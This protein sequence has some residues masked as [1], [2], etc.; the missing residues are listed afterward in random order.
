MSY[1]EFL[2]YVVM[3]IC[4]YVCISSIHSNK[5]VSK[6]SIIGPGSHEYVCIYV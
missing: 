2:K 5:Y 6:Y 1:H 4:M 3:Q